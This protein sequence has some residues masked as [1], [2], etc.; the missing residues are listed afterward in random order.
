MACFGVLLFLLTFS[1]LAPW[2]TLDKSKDANNQ[3]L[4]LS[5]EKPGFSTQVLLRAKNTNSNQRITHWPYDPPNSKNTEWIPID[6]LS[7]KEGF[8]VQAWYGGV[9]RTLDM[10]D[11]LYKMSP[12][13][14]KEYMGETI[15]YKDQKGVGFEVEKNT[16]QNLI[17][18]HHIFQARYILGTDK[19]GRD[20]LSRLARGLRIS[21]FI[22]FMAVM[23]SI[24]IGVLVGATGGYYGGRIDNSI[25]L[26]INTSWSIPTLLLAFAIII[27][28][29]KGMM[30]IVLAVG[31]TMWVDVARL[32]RGQVMQ[33]KN[34]HYIKAAKILGYKSQRIIVRHI[35]PNIMGPLL[36]IASANFATAVL[37]EA[38][39]SYLG[40]GIQPPSPSLG[41][42]L[43]ENYAY[44]T[45]GFIYLAIFPIIMIMSLV[46]CFNLLGT[47]LRDA[48]D[49][50]RTK[51]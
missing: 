45:G 11:I 27:A 20:N 48:F 49:V 22:G 16:G 31:L 30:V 38:G 44:A 39:L 7:F 2:I 17:Y 18:D 10:A 15:V 13:M 14:V 9:N 1:L 40:L 51:A 47:S 5:L 28:F 35:L 50:K 43:Q 12:G 42:M 19:Y 4:S 34:E 23:V 32:I 41:N 33:I 36:V 46:L 37:V 25:L 26:L 6:S 8:E 3:V 29:G 24:L 21:I